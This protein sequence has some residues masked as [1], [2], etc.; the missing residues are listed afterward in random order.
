M[1]QDIPPYKVLGACNPS[2]AAH[3]VEME[4]QIGALLPCN[5]V[6]R[7]D[8]EGKVF[9]EAMDPEKVLTM[10]QQEGI[11]DLAKGVREKLTK[12]LDAI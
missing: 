6:V 11:A 2:L 1:F 12:A 8:A 5:V 3:A 4:P 10:V 7:Q 9:V